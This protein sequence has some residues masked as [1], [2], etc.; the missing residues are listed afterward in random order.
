MR[1]RLPSILKDAALTAFVAAALGIF[2]V[3]FR[4]VDV[5]SRTGLSFDYQLADLA[6]AVGAIFVGRIG[7]SL[8]AAGL[9]WPVVALGAAMMAVGA[10]PLQL[11]SGFLHW[12][13]ALGGV[14]L[15]IRGIWPW[16][17]GT[18]AAAASTPSGVLL[19]QAGAKWFGWLL[20]AAAVLLPFTPAADQKTTSPSVPE[21]TAVPPGS[22]MNANP[23]MPTATP[24]R[25]NRDGRC[26]ARTRSRTTQSAFTET[27][28]A[29]TPLG[30]CCSDN[31]TVPIP[32]PR[33]I[34]P[35]R[36][37]NA[38]SWTLTRST[39]MPLNTMSPTP[40]IAAAAMKRRAAES[41]GGI[42]WVVTAIAR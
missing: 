40:R 14:M 39:R 7:L 19:G 26:P 20:L 10:S 5:G 23:T 37:E 9:R 27:R 24:A 8:A 16:A 30:M 15:V 13:V 4:T 21:T 25:V 35:M 29:A 38:T 1:V 33:S 17:R 22:S 31:E 34:T 12:F 42:V 36:P 6:V 41:K 32:T 2:I 3:G 18:L 28:R 11:P